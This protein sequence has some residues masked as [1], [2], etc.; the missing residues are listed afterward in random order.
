MEVTLQERIKALGIYTLE[1][2]KKTERGDLIE[3]F[4]LLT[5][6]E[7]IDSSKFSS[8]HRVQEISEVTT[9][10]YLCPEAD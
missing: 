4:K 9:R 6:K 3:M 1:F 5:E 8:L 7:G 2:E 10:N